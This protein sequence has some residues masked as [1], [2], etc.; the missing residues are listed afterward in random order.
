MR[1]KTV[2]VRQASSGV[3]WIVRLSRAVTMPTLLAGK[4]SITEANAP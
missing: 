1:A 2:T 3:Q 4:R